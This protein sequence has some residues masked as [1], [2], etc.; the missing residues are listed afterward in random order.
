[1]R[2]KLAPGERPVIW[3]ASSKK[4]LLA[5]PHGVIRG[6]GIALG[7]AQRGG[8][9]PSAK[10]WKGE[11]GWRDGNRQRLRFGHL[12]SGVHDCL[13]RGGLRPSLFSEEVTAGKE[14]CKDRC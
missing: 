1:M 4:D 7:V 11:G 9:D 14:D 12:P 3:M 2:T 5:M 6:I 13:S 8:K 10:P